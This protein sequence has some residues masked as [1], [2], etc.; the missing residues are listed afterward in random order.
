MFD[1][2]NDEYEGVPKNPV[3]DKMIE[4]IELL[5]ENYIPPFMDRFSEKMHEIT[6]NEDNLLLTEDELKKQVL[7]KLG[8]TTLEEPLTKF[9]KH[10]IYQKIQPVLPLQETLR[11]QALKQV[12]ETVQAQVNNAVQTINNQIHQLISPD[13]K[14][15]PL[16]SL[17]EMSEDELV[18]EVIG[19]YVEIVEDSSESPEVDYDDSIEEYPAVVSGL[20][21]HPLEE[22]IEEAQEVV[23]R[24]VSILAD[25]SAILDLDGLKDRLINRLLEKYSDELKERISDEEEFLKATV[26]LKKRIESIVEEEIAKKKK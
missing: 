5:V 2:S 20:V 6:T 26:L 8:I 24:P 18:A 11:D 16:T 25:N 19:E 13:V 22:H 17:G 21:E 23:E 15:E 10:S 1:K 12:K 14:E 4:E 3:T 9:I 7:E